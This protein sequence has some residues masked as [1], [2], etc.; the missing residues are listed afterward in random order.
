MPVVRQVK[1]MGGSLG[2]IIPRDIAESM[3]VEEG[4]EVVLT[5]VDRQLVVEPTVDAVDAPS[6]QRAFAAVLRRDGAG[7]QWLADYDRGR[8]AEER[9]TPSARTRRK[10]R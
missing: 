1:K 6:F 8:H 7:F 5:L 10:K 2:I 3:G 9:P 4:S